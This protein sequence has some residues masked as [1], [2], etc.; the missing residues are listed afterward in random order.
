MTTKADSD[1]DSESTL[2]GM[3]WRERWLFLPSIRKGL[4]LLRYC[5]A[6]SGDTFR[7]AA[8]CDECPSLI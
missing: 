6:T 3:A 1:G 5:L 7:F 2:F 8:C 4:I